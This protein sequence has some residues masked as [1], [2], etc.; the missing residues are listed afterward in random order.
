MT[1]VA[2]P[3]AKRWV[4]GG[5]MRKEDPKL[6]TGQGR[7]T[8][9]IA[10]PGMLWLAFVRSPVAHA[11]IASIDTSAA[12][13]LP[14]VVAVYTG[15]ELADEWA[16][17]MP[18]AWP[19]TSRTYPGEATARRA[20]PRPLAGGQGPG[21]VHGRDRGRG[22]G[23]QP[24]ARLRRHRGGRRRLRRAAGGHRHRGGR[25]RRRPRHPRAVRQQR[26][27]HLGAAQRRRR[28]GLRRGPGGGL[29]ALLPPPADR[30]RDRAAGHRGPAGAGQR[31]VHR[32][33]GDPDPALPPG[34]PDPH[35]RHP[36][37]QDPGD[38]PRGRR[39]LRLQ[40]GGLRRGV[41][42]RRPGP[43]ARPA[44]Q[45]ERVPLRGLPVHRPGPRRDPG[46]GGRRH[47]G[48]QAARRAGQAPGRHGRLRVPGRSGHPH[49]RRLPLPRRVRLRGLQL[50]LHLG[51]HQQDP[52]R[53]LPG[54]RPAR[55]DLCDRAGH[56]RARPPGRQG[57]GRGPGDELHPALRPAPDDG[58]HAGVRLGQLRGHHSTRPRSWSATT[59]C[60]A[61]S[62]P[63]T[64]AATASCSVSA[65]PATSRCA[66]GPRRRCW[67]RSSTPAA[68]GSGP[69]IRCNPTGKVTV[70][71][72]T[73]PHGQGHD[74]TFVADRRR[75][76]R[77]SPPTTS[78]CCTAT[79]RCRPGAGLLRQP[80]HVG[81]GRGH[82]E[83]GRAG[84]GEG[85]DAGR[86]RARG[87]RG[88]PRVDGRQVPG[89]GRPRPGQDRSPSSP[90]PP[91]RPTRCRTRSTRAWRRTRGLRPAQLHLP[92]RR[93]TSAWSR[94]T[95]RP[96]RPG[97]TSTWPS[98]TAAPS[99]TR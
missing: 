84:P 45:V 80:Q 23:R 87:G 9:D 47:R 46:H 66:A 8:D 31:R 86:P 15:E 97:S 48:G 24:R 98:T 92:V 94:S 37:D 12:K 40:A 44:G 67:A 17:A 21:P 34:V 82:P 65:S 50:Q 16:A 62:R 54:R 5:L 2:E 83:G 79:P 99:S 19:V 49:P 26:D 52:D 39:R 25:G 13:E 93:P 53:R 33:V 90:S 71:S 85:P 1:Q 3:E 76:P 6:I 69:S 29:R 36:R 70:I 43:Q 10:L 68:A 14:G 28:Q 7:Y 4:G 56:G 57:P 75:R 30:Q 41:H 32:L 59:S 88:R 78:R 95:R 96:A 58:R 91:G 42:H 63:T 72:G 18:C 60:A 73:S 35:P 81:R 22:R 64:A 61:S 11:N 77:A 89:Q 27:V 55:G 20:R 74:T 51:V 38:R